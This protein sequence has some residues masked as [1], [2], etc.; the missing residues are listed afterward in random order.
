MRSLSSAD[1]SRGVPHSK[2]HPVHVPINGM[3]CRSSEASQARRNALHALQRAV[4]ALGPWDLLRQGTGANR[5][6][7]GGAPKWEGPVDRWHAT[8]SILLE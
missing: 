7:T 6:A 1:A 2:D 3:G 5:P 4:S 8:S